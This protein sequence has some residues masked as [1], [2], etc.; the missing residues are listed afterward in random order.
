MHVVLKVGIIGK[1]PTRVSANTVLWRISRA[2][3]TMKYYFF[4]LSEASLISDNC[5][6]FE[7][8]LLFVFIS[9]LYMTV[10]GCS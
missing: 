9:S 4:P 7:R 8:F 2:E 10:L 6:Y 3:I 1:L 5:K